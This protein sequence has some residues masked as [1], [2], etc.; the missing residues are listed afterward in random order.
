MKRSAIAATAMMKVQSI[1]SRILAVCLALISCYLVLFFVYYEVVRFPASGKL[2]EF[3]MLTRRDG[4][5]GLP[6]PFPK[7]LLEFVNK[8]L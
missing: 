5:R 8:Q 1:S 6:T 4:M 7:L 2:E 3:R